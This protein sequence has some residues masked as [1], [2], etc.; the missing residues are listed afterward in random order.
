MTFTIDLPSDVG[1]AIGAR[2]VVVTGAT[3]REGVWNLVASYPNARS[4][5]VN[6]RNEIRQTVVGLLN[7]KTL[8][9]EENIPDGSVVELI[10]ISVG[11]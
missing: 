9:G 7:C 6:S 4:L 2:Q 5:L 1:K 11:G 3:Y 10:F 8:S